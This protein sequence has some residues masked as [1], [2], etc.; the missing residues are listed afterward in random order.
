MP[1]RTAPPPSRRPS[2]Q[3]ADRSWSTRVETRRAGRQQWITRPSPACSP[4]SAT[5]WR[6]RTRILSGFGPTAPPPKRSR[7][8]VERIADIPPAERLKLQGIGKDL[9]TKIGELLDTG[10]LEYH[11]ALLREFPSDRPR[12]P[13]PARC[14]SEDRRAALQVARD[15][16]PSKTSRRPRARTAARDERDGRKER[17]AHPEGNRG[18]QAARQPPAAERRARRSPTRSSATSVRRRRKPPSRP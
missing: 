14:R 18:A 13:A 5:C 2:R 12:R 10:S 11:Q 3:P 15:Q 8:W 16:D 9:A 17:G 6:S 1:S 7:R 4:R